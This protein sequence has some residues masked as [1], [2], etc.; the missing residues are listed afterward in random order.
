[1][2]D[3][4]DSAL[5]SEPDEEAADEQSSSRGFVSECRGTSSSSC[6]ASRNGFVFPL[7]ANNKTLQRCS[8]LRSSQFASSSLINVTSVT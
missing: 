6:A 4:P 8:F 2:R 1:M 5:R 7:G 3:I